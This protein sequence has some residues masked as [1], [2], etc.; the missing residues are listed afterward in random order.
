MARARA[1]L[2]DNYDSYAEILAHAIA[3]CEG[4]MPWCQERRGALFG[5]SRGAGNDGD[6]RRDRA[7]ARD[8][9]RES[10]LGV[11][12]ALVRSSA[13]EAREMPIFGVC[14]GHQALAALAAAASSER[15]P[16]GRGARTRVRGA[17]RR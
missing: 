14:L 16:R 8:A 17:T 4:A 13:A 2:I 1:L 12:D 9:G 7:G 6:A 11:G 15:N 3:R 5:A 10:D